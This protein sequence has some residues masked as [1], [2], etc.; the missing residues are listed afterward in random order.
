[1]RRWGWRADNDPLHRLQRP[2]L[3]TLPTSVDR[4]G[5]L[6][7]LLVGGE[8][9]DGVSDGNRLSEIEMLRLIARLEALPPDQRAEVARKVDGLEA[10]AR[11]RREA[12]K[13][14]ESSTP[15]DGQ[16]KGGQKWRERRRK[17]QQ[18]KRKDNNNE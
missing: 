1:M 5:A 6:H 4:R 10:R 9:E 18:E 14:N 8:M 17:Y 3:D 11:L 2:V 12:G 16:I 7:L 13:D 15:A